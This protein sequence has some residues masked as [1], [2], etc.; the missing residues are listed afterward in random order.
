MSNYY[1]TSYGGYRLYHHGILGMK[2]GVRRYQNPD[3]SLTEAGKKRYAKIEGKIAKKERQIEKWQKK[4]DKRAGKDYRAEKK[5]YKASKIRNR[6]YNGIVLGGTK[7]RQAMLF[8]A[9]RLDA[10]ASQLENKS[11]KYQAK[12]HKAQ[13]FINK[14]NRKLDRLDPSRTKAGSRYISG[15][16]N[17]TLSSINKNRR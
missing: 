17:T 4:I 6:A 15:Y 1:G 8:K 5:R 16:A 7:K 12:I 13:A 9:D 10:K 14:Q 2:W 3:G 11:M